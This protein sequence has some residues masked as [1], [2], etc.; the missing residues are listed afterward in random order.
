MN[1]ITEINFRLKVRKAL[2]KE[3]TELVEITLE[4][5]NNLLKK[6]KETLIK[7]CKHYK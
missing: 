4:E 3:P 1:K 6:R 5:C 7:K 2:I